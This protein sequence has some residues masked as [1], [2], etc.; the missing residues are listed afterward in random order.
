M[1]SCQDNHIINK[2][3]NLQHFSDHL[4]VDSKSL[5]GINLDME[6]WKST[7]IFYGRSDSFCESD[8]FCIYMIVLVAE[9]KFLNIQYELRSPRAW[10]LRFSNFF[11]KLKRPSSQGLDV[12][13]NWKLIRLFFYHHWTKSVFISFYCFLLYVGLN[14][15]AIYS[16]WICM[17]SSI[18]S[19]GT[20]IKINVS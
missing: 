11:R 13:N 10:S 3:H 4:G 5:N 1:Y 15:L 16:I 14:L 2:K 20:A 18:S 12:I 19:N 9:W 6:L 7:Y 17:L 8:I